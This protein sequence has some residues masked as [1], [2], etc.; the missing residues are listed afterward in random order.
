MGMTYIKTEI[1]LKDLFTI[2]ANIKNTHTAYRDDRC[3]FASFQILQNKRQIMCLMWL[4][5]FLT[6]F[7][8]SVT[9]V[10]VP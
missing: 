10:I 1:L 7:L 8:F 4:F 5:I 9:S 2:F 6:S 3:Y